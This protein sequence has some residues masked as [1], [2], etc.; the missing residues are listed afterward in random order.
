MNRI[1]LRNLIRIVDL[2]DLKCISILDFSNLSAECF[3]SFLNNNPQLEELRLESN[4]INLVEALHNRSSIKILTIVETSIEMNTNLPRITMDSLEKLTLNLRSTKDYMNILRAL[5]CKRI[6]EMKLDCEEA[7]DDL[8]TAYSSFT[9]LTLLRLI[10]L[11]FKEFPIQ[12]DQLR[13]LSHL[14]PHLNQFDMCIIESESNLERYVL[15]VF[16]SFSGVIETRN[17]LG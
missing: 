4:V 3:T 8:I 10:L 7:D 5:D 11:R 9:S 13:Q 2:K 14:L 1:E 15:F 16:F 6:K 17:F 12:M